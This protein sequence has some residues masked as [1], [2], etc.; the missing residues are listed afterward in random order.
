MNDDG[1]G[2]RVLDGMMSHVACAV[3]VFANHRFGLTVPHSI[4]ARA[5]EVI[6]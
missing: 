2:R 3:K 1:H 5:D 6:E 4:L